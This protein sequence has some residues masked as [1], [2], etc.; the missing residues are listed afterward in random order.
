MQEKEKKQPKSQGGKTGKSLTSNIL[1]R[2]LRGRLISTDFF[3]RHWIT[4]ALLVLMFVW[5]ITNKYECQTSMET[6][7]KLEKELEIVRTERVREQSSYMSRI[8]ESS[9]LQLVR[10]NRLDLQIQDTPPYKIK[11]NCEPAH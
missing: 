1:G 4:V 8:R 9:M 2:A 3:S 7:Q 5:Y 11:Y 6:I 10:R